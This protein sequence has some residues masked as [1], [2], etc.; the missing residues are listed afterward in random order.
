MREESN[1]SSSDGQHNV[2][3]VVRHL[4]WFRHPQGKEH[5]LAAPVVLQT[6]CNWINV[7][8]LGDDCKAGVGVLPHP[9]TTRQDRICLG[10]LSPWRGI[11]I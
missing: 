7:H 10:E 3:A 5:P 9:V 4:Q 8:A 6:A 2:S 11:L 1:M